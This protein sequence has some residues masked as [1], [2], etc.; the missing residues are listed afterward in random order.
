M[1]L[2]LIAIP[3]PSVVFVVSRAIVLGRRAAVLS[4]LGNDFGFLLQLCAV[5]VGLG[6]LM[7]ASQTLYSAVRLAGAV[8]LVY[9]GVQAWRH[10]RELAATVAA[11]A[12][13][14]TRGHRVFRQGIL[15][16]LTNPKGIVVFTAIVPQFTVPGHD[17]PVQIFALGLVC[18]L[19]AVISDVSWG[20][21]AGTARQWLGRSACRLET[22]SGAGAVTMVGLGVSMAV[23]D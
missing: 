8:Y 16:G 3:G 23:D 14:L 12:P 18:V 22:I 11:G 15:V 1:I 19:I 9:L 5:S 6:S 20:L 4:A 13:E 7:A 17:L 21:A 10:C 2:T